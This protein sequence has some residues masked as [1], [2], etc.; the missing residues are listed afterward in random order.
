MSRFDEIMGQKPATWKPTKPTAAQIAAIGRALPTGAHTLT[1]EQ[2]R[3]WFGRVV[4]DG[5]VS[6]DGLA[7]VCGERRIKP[8]DV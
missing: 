1:D 2:Q 4:F 6:W 8:E 3:A 5:P 7:F